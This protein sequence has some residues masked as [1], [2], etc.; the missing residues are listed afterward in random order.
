MGRVRKGDPTA[1]PAGGWRS[2]GAVRSILAREDALGRGSRVL[3]HQNKPG[4]VACVGCA[5]TKPAKPHA[6]EFC[7]QGAKAAAWELSA[8]RVTPEFLARRPLRTLETVDDHTLESWG[9]LTAPMRWDPST[10]CY[11]AVD[12]DS[13]FDEIARELRAIDPKSAVFYASGRASLETCYLY[14]LMVRMYGCNNFPDCSNMCHE[15]TSVGLKESIGVPV[16]TVTLDDLHKTDCMLFFGENVGT[17]APRML[18]D[19]HAARRR[20]VPIITFNPLRERGL[21]SY[22]NPLSPLHMLTPKKTRISTQYHQVR[23]GGDTAAIAGMCKALIA[24]DDAAAAAGEPRVIDA[25]FVAEHTHGFEAFAGFVRGTSWGDIERESSLA[26]EAIEAAAREYANAEAAIALYGMGLTQHRSG[27][28]NVQMLCNLLLLRGNVGKPG[29]GIAPVR[30]HSNVQGQRT[31]GITEKPELA[32]LDKLAELYGFEPPR[33]RG[34]NT[35]RSCEGIVGGDVRA[36]VG[37]GGNFLRVVPDSARLEPAWRKLRLTVQIATKLNRSHVLHGE[38]AYVLPCLGRLEVDRQA[39][40]EQAVTIEDATGCVHGSRGYAEPASPML[41]SEPWIVAELAKALIEANERVDWDG[42]VADYGRIREAIARTYPEIFH[43]FNARMW[44]PGGFHRPLKARERV[45]DTASGKASFV[46]PSGLVENPDMP[47]RGEDVLRLITLRSSDQFTSSVYSYD[48]PYR[49]IHGS[50]RVLLMNRRDMARLGI[51]EG[52]AVSASTCADDAPRRI[53][54]LRAI[55]Y[56]IPE[57]CAG[58]Y[59][60]ECNPLIPLW[61]HAERA[62]VPAAKYIAVRVAREGDGNAG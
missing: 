24:W 48:D 12:W 37:L 41:R 22:A 39:S 42:W 35:V 26:R 29:A 21:V 20:G 53:G 11:V 5:W 56:D 34:R 50:R 51:E 38:V 14:Q 4:G 47:A 18:H 45:W 33:E 52:Q 31:V 36:F 19:L 59:Y 49:E 17:N 43:D 7:D 58:G 3:W 32:P 44:T 9:R 1:H 60:P 2:I 10:D 40:G 15:S 28:A 23:V 46:V 62:D 25:A 6:V 54:G 13:A 55:A 16:G 57:G 30:G 61:H 8:R 27:V